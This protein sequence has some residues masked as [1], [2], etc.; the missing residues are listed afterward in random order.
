MQTESKY[1]NFSLI[2][3]RLNGKNLE[4]IVDKS[5]LWCPLNGKCNTCTVYLAVWDSLFKRLAIDQ[6]ILVLYPKIVE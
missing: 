6:T 4:L 1:S 3:S 5:I 2:N